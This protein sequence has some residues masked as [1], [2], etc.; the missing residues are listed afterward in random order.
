[1]KFAL[2]DLLDDDSTMTAIFAIVTPLGAVPGRPLEGREFLDRAVRDFD[3]DAQGFVAYLATQA[4]LWF[5]SLSQPPEW[6][7]E[8]EW[9][10]HEGKPMTF[11]GQV[12]VPAAVGVFHDDA[13]FFVFWDQHDGATRTVIQ[14]A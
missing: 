6:I 2:D 11:V 1:M 5:R 13:R 4:P 7:Q 10:F 12:E 9:Q 3:G 8:A 14:V